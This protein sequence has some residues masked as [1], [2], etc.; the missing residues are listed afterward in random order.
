MNLWWLLWLFQVASRTS[1]FMYSRG[2]KPVPCFQG[3]LPTT[4]TITTHHHHDRLTRQSIFW[5]NPWI[6]KATISNT[7]MTMTTT[8]S[9]TINTSSTTSLPTLSRSIL[10]T[11]DPCVV[12]MKDLMGQHANL[13]RDKGG[14]VS[15]AQGVVYWTPPASA[16]TAMKDAMQADEDTAAA[17]C[18]SSSSSSAPQLHMYG[19]DEGVWELRQVLQDKIARENGLHHHSVMVTVGANQAYMNAVLTLLDAARG[20][21]SVVFGPYYFNH[22]MA[23]QMVLPA[24]STS[25]SND[26]ILIGPTCETDGLPD[27]DWLE[28]QLQNDSSIQMVTLVNP[29]NPTG[30]HLPRALIQRAVDLCREYSCWLIL[31]CTYEYFI[32]DAT[33]ST[34]SSPSNV[35]T[36]TYRVSTEV[37][38]NTDVTP[39]SSHTLLFDGC[40]SDPHV[41]HIFSLSKSYA[42]AGYRCGY[43]VTSHDVPDVYQNMLKVQDTIPIAPSRIAQYAA[44][45][46]L[47]GAGPTWVADR[48]ATLTTGRTAVQAALRDAGVSR[49]MGGSGAMY[50]MAQ[51]P[52]SSSSSIYGS[53]ADD[54]AVAHTLVQDHG[55][56][57]IPGSFCGWPGWI[58]VCY[59]N[60]PPELC[61]AAAER[62]RQGLQAILNNNG[63]MQ[64]G[65]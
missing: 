33:K 48:V 1:S 64:E 32:H 22:V 11:L 20:D 39:S 58:R 61:V 44:L 34:E 43:I 29:G 37:N 12:L 24:T 17:K 28:T 53:P 40:F 26:A 30:V 42:L 60:L 50:L 18:P 27:L 46:A 16:M 35:T 8:T 36:D 10:H 41:V 25:T 65:A 13:W 45:G 3:L 14:I 62:L 5:K 47:R 19:P 52:S 31:D 49:V 7:R 54:V 15:L 4:G 23:L 56:A 55:V 59:A 38:K 21:K 51:L 63:D 2:L 57:I 9:S 6:S